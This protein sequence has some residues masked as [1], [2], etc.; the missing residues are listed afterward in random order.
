[1]EQVLAAV[2]HVLLA[3]IVLDQATRYHVP[4]AR[5]VQEGQAAALSVIWATSVLDQLTRYPVLQTPTLTKQVLIIDLITICQ[6]HLYSFKIML[7]PPHAVLIRL[8]YIVRFPLV[9]QY[10]LLVAYPKYV[11]PKMPKS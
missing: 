2:V 9:D 4:Q 1:M 7:R 8:P 6:S 11:L 10:W 5:T 3:T